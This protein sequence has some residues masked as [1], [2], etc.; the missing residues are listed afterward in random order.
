MATY[1]VLQDIEAEDKFLGPL[2]LKQFIFLAITVLSGYL[3][4]FFLTK[5]LWYLAIP[6]IPLIL[7]CGFLAFPWGRDQ[8]TEVWLLAKIRFFIKP[9]RRIW[10]QSGMQELV[11]ITAPKHVEE[12]TSDNLSQTEVKSRLK[13]LAET[14]DSRG[15]AVKNVTVDEY[16]RAGQPAVSNSD[17][18]VDI[19]TLPQ[20]ATTTLDPAAGD[21]IFDSPLASQVAAQITQ[22]DDQHKLATYDRLDEIRE[23]QATGTPENTPNFWFMNQQ[24]AAPG[25][26]S[27][28][29][30]TVP[31]TDS[32]LLPQN[33]RKPF[34]VNSEDSQVL[35]KIHSNQAQSHQSFRNHKSVSPTVA[36]PA[37]TANASPVTAAPDAATIELARNNDQVVSNL[38]RETNRLHPQ[39][40]GQSDDD[41]VIITLH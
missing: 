12:N 1:K 2:T 8:P 25:M 41:E 18:L 24:S 13:A 21:D 26:A 40:G 6:L 35:Q 29:T 9:R 7:V 30:Q 38:A 32:Q 4:F 33:L 22:S 34:P 28:G 17:R 23:K 36:R 19:S 14:I 31:S 37:H 3:C 16:A 5:H 10:D 11:R 39:T 20:V 27:F 15:W